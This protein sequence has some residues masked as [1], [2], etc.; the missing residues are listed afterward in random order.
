MRSSLPH[1][2]CSKG[3]CGSLSYPPSAEWAPLL[4]AFIFPASS[5][6]TCCTIS[7]YPLPMS[8]T[9]LPPVSHLPPPYPASPFRQVTNLTLPC[10]SLLLASPIRCQPMHTPAR[11][12]RYYMFYRRHTP[13]FPNLPKIVRRNTRTLPTMCVR[14]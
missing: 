9:C 10:F 13:Q 8:P 1:E 12:L 4:I 14:Q 11:D 3:A 7:F 6:A 5:L 2:A